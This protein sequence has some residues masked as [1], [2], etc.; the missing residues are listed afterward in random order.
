MGNLQTK[1]GACDEAS[2]TFQTSLTKYP[3]VNKDKITQY[4]ESSTK[5]AKMI[6]EAKKFT[7]KKSYAKA[8]EL[9]DSALE[10]A[11]NA[12]NL[13]IDLCRLLKETQQW[14]R[15][16]QVSGMILRTQP[17]HPE[18]LYMRGWVYLML[19][20]KDTAK[21]HFAKVAFS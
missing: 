21:S 2:V 18:M 6:E 13:R 19:G 11:S 14:E 7:V 9:L 5:C 3:L 12:N 16:Q 17:F 1:L 20:D 15:L 10:I 8:I 4:L